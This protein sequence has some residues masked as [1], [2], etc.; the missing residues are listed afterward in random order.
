MWLFQKCF[1]YFPL[2]HEGHK[3][4]IYNIENLFVLFAALW[5]TFF[6]T[7]SSNI[8]KSVFLLHRH[9]THG[10]SPASCKFQAQHRFTVY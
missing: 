1:L 10:T 6:E 3:A 4:V 7:A 5:E 9:Y 2:R 8:L